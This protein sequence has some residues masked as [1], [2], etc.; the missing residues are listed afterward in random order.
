MS[1]HIHGVQATAETAT[2]SASTKLTAGGSAV[3]VAGWITDSNIGL[4]AGILIGLAGLLV[5]WFYQ[6][7]RDRR[8]QERHEALLKG[9]AFPEL[10]KSPHDEAL[11]D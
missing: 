9:T 2:I 8:E 11:Q 10:D 4:I 5:N 3:S 7:R 6:Y 1:E